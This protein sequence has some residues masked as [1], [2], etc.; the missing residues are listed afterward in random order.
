MVTLL[1]V[2]LLYLCA[3]AKKLNKANTRTL[4][5]SEAVRSANIKKRR[6]VRV[7]L[8]ICRSQVSL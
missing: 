3:Q 1:I 5:E 6:K 4:I 8:I 7:Q 2:S